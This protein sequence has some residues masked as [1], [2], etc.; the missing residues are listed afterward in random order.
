MVK[1]KHSGF[2]EYLRYWLSINNVL[3]IANRQIHETNYPNYLA[4]SVRTVSFVPSSS[5]PLPVR[6]ACIS[7]G[8]SA[9]SC[10]SPGTA[11]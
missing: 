6:S 7:S 8:P 4:R 9:S 11:S 1:Q 3:S 5:C 2:A 10:G